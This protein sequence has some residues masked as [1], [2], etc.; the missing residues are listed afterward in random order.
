MISLAEK[1]N[2]SQI[3]D[4]WKNVLLSYNRLNKQSKDSLSDK[5]A[6]LRSLLEV[7]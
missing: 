4:M 2:T 5:L 3:P 1:G 6:T 7:K